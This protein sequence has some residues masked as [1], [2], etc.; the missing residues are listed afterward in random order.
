MHCGH[1]LAD[2]TLVVVSV[3]QTGD[4]EQDHEDV[5]ATAVAAYIVLLGAHARGLAGYWRTPAVLRTEEGA[6][7]VGIPADELFIALLQS[8]L[9]LGPV[10]RLLASLWGGE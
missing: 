9:P 6:E 1:G 7:A 2:R 10:E 5:L 3:K 4:A 8:R